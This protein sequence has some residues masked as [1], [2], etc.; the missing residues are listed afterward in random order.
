[1]KTRVLS[2]FEGFE[3]PEGGTSQFG[4]EKGKTLKK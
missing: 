2:I 4:G 3:K 1:M